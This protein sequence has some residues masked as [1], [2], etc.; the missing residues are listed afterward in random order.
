M[1]HTLNDLHAWYK[2]IKLDLMECFLRLFIA[3][4]IKF[5]K[6]HLLEIY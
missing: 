4:V 2:R 5:K 3:K 1:P 6:I